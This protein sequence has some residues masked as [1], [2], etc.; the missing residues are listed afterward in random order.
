MGDLQCGHS[1]VIQ[2]TNPRPLEILKYPIYPAS[3]MFV[4]LHVLLRFASGL[5]AGSL[6]SATLFA[7]LAVQAALL[8]AFM[9]RMPFN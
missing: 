6:A 2:V 1:R 5:C 9:Q 7:W 8:E 3:I 4:R